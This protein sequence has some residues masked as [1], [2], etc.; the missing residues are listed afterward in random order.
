[1]PKSKCGNEIDVYL[2]IVLP[3][4]R[5]IIVVSDFYW[6]KMQDVII[7]TCNNI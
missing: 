3:Y 7:H 1:M 2:S 4:H 6:T 5:N